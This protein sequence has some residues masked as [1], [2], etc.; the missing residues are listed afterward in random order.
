M[1]VASRAPIA[2]SGVGATGPAGPAG[3]AGA[4]GAPGP[5]GPTGPAGANATNL[6]RVIATGTTYTVTDNQQQAF[7]RREVIRGTGRLVARGTALIGGLR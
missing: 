2:T 6:P 1:A 4:D 5:A 3:P 7:I